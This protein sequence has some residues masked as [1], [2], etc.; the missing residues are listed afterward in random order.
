MGCR[1][2]ALD[3]LVDTLRRE[4]DTYESVG[5]A[6]NGAKLCR[7]VADQIAAAH[8]EWQYELLTVSEAAQETGKHY[9][10]ISRKLKAGKLPNLGTDTHPKVRRVDLYGTERTPGPALADRILGCQS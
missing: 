1:V 8:R 10:T 7:R 6:V 4:A 3:S 9:S 5:A 2:Q